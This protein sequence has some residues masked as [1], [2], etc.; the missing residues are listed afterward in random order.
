MK[1]PMAFE[2]EHTPK[3]MQCFKKAFHMAEDQHH[4]TNLKKQKAAEMYGEWSG[5]LMY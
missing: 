4:E 3:I 1:F 5:V 2:S